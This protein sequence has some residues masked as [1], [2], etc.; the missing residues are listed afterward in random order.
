MALWLTPSG[1][2]DLMR[3]PA[4]VRILGHLGY[5]AYVALILGA[6]AGV[7]D[8]AH[9]DPPPAELLLLLYGLHRND[10]MPKRANCE[11]RGSILLKYSLIENNRERHINCS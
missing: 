9:R 10:G 8:G 7:D 11:S 1:V 3:T 4:V 2:L 6:V 5:P